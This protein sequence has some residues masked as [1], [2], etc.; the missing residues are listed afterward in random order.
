MKLDLNVKRPNRYY[1]S[2]IIL[3]PDASEEE[4]KTILR[5]NRDIIKSFEG[6][7]THLDTWGKRRLGNQIENLKVGTYYHAMFEA[8]PE[9]IAELERNMR[10]N[11]KVLRFM[12]VS[13][14]D[15]KDLS[16]H[17]EDY[18]EVLSKSTKREQEREAKAQ[19]RRAGRDSKPRDRSPASGGGS[20]R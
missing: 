18:R 9:S 16:K 19:A 1:E 17:L 3:H 20:N 11:D 4:Q 10:I 2:V 6:E 14:D 7:L 12:H 8:Q 13:L 5:K 15:R